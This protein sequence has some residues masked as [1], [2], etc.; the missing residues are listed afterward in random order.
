MH[1][2]QHLDFINGIKTKALRDAVCNQLQD[3]S[4]HFFR[5]FLFDKIK[6]V[7]RIVGTV[8]IQIRDDPFVDFV[9]I[10]NDPASL[11][12]AKYFIQSDHRHRRRGNNI[13]KYIA[14][15]NRWQLIDITD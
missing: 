1:G 2:G 5:V 6:I 3:N 12:L 15:P 4:Q 9:G 8:C 13:I 7:V 10:H 14:G 11:S